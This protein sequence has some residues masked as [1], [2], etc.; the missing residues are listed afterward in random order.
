MKP[1]TCC[2]FRGVSTT[3]VSVPWEPPSKS[4]APPMWQLLESGRNPTIRDVLTEQPQAVPLAKSRA[5]DCSSGLHLFLFPST[6][7][8]AFCASKLPFLQKI[9]VASKKESF[10]SLGDAL[11][12]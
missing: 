11:K 9:F 3:L 12:Q 4:F 1:Q 10:M 5:Y 8:G 6:L 7:A 2:I